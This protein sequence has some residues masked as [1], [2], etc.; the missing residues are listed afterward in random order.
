M[1]IIT[2]GF[3][4]VGAE[5]AIMESEIAQLCQSLGVRLMGPNCL[6]VL[7]T[8]HKINATFAP[9]LPPAGKISLISQSGA[10]CVAILDWAAKQRLGMRRSFFEAL[11]RNTQ[12]TEIPLKLMIALKES[13]KPV[14]EDRL[15][16]VHHPLLDIAQPG[17]LSLVPKSIVPMRVHARPDRRQGVSLVAVAEDQKNEASFSPFAF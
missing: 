15:T 8:H 7:N 17:L 3:K 11:P 13:G 1:I 10:L 5:G 9:A 16:S 14:A 2:A 12:Q 4:E 6:G